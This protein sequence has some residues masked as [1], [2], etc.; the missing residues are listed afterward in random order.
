MAGTMWISNNEE[1]HREDIAM[2]TKNIIFY[3][4][5]PIA[6]GLLLVALFH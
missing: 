2:S 3:F 1:P 5:G 6:L 4:F